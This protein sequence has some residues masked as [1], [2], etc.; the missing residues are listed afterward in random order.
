MKQPTTTSDYLNESVYYGGYWV[1]RHQMIRDLQ[2]I[3][4][5]NFPGNLAQQTACVNMYLAGHARK[6]EK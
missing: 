4:R 1:P 2:S 6:E 3:A 5:A